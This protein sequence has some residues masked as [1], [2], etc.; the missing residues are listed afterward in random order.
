ML[1]MG[2]ELATRDGTSLAAPQVAGLVA[3]LVDCK[4]IL[5]VWPEALKPIIMASAMHSIEPPNVMQFYDG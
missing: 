4:P 1:G 3:L 5:W 2:N